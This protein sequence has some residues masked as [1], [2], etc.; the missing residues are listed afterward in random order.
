M[1]VCKG[2]LKEKE[3]NIENFYSHKGKLSNKC[4]MCIKEQCR[5]YAKKIPVK[6]KESQI[7]HYEKTKDTSVENRVRWC[8]RERPTERKCKDCSQVFPNTSEFLAEQRGDT[9][10]L[11][12][13]CYKQQRKLYTQKVR[14]KLESGCHSTV[15]SKLAKVARRRQ[16]HLER[17][18]SD[19]L[20]AA[21]YTARQVVAKAF[22]RKSRKKELETEKILGCS[23]EEFKLYIEALFTDG[24]SWQ[25]RESWHIDH[26]LPLASAT[27]VE[28]VLKLNHYRNLQPLWAIDNLRKGCN[29]MKGSS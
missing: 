1:K 8:G 5:D 20:Y 11:C 25:N 29:I 21:T 17:L 24:M 22:N 9:R 26:I 23:F 7:K 10:N 19:R 16:R 2:C 12:I 3:S 15:E 13:S 28:D 18:E 6:I 27:T 4:K 14:E